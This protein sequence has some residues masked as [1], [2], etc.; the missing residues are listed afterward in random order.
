MSKRVLLISYE[1]GLGYNRGIY[2]FSKSLIRAI[3]RQHELGLLTQAYNSESPEILASL[4]EPSHYFRKKNAQTILW[5]YYLKYFLG[6]HNKFEFTQN[7]HSSIVDSYSDAI[8]FFINKSAFYYYNQQYLKLPGLGLHNLE[9]DHLNTDDIIFSTSPVNMRSGKNKMI[10]TLHDVFPLVNTDRY[11]QR[12]F[13]RNIHGLTAADKIIAV[14]NYAKKSFLDYYPDL[15]N[16][17][18]VVYQAIAIDTHLIEQSKDIHLNEIVLNKY[19]LKPKSYMFFVGAIEY[20]KNI[21]NMIQAYRL[22]TKGHNDLKLVIAGKSDDL[23]YLSEFGLLR[24]MQDDN[25]ENIQFVGEINNLE[26][27]CLM[28]NCRAFLFPSLLEGFGIPVVEA[29]TLGTP[30]LTSNNSAL[31]EVAGDSAFLV[32]NPEDLEELAD[33]IRQLWDNDE[34]CCNLSRKGFENIKR[35]SFDTF[36]DNVNRIINSV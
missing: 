3:K 27:I 11:Y 24:Y 32:N 26:K 18:E 19:C 7:D 31:T 16:K 1:M 33:G 15:E 4:H 5:G 14:S 12:T 30:V 8:D 6:F 34:L 36:S 17:I 35:F 23:K 28:K 20:R 22:A 9:I 13:H 29:Q 10:Q 2:H 25:T 21:H